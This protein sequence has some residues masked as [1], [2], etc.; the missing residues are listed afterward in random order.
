M[1]FPGTP[2][3]IISFTINPVTHGNPINQQSWDI[4]VAVE[5]VE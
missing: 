3:P 4:K 1:T 2:N 5:Y